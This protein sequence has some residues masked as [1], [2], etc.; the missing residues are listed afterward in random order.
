MNI[1]SMPHSKIVPNMIK[2][3]STSIVEKSIRN[4]E[5]NKYYIF[6]SLDSIYVATVINCPWWM[7]IFSC[8]MSDN[9]LLC[10]VGLGPCITIFGHCPCVISCFVVVALSMK[11][12]L[13]FYI[14]DPVVL[15][16]EICSVLNVSQI[17]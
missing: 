15:I 2:G 4:N 5:T 7:H 11:F 9:F 6:F 12:E 14:S 3:V 13:S 1:P 8:C 17:W 10:C 16:L